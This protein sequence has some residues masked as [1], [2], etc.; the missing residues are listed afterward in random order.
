MSER[1]PIIILGA[2][3][4]GTRLVVDILRT[5]GSLPGRIDNEW[6]EDEVFLDVHRRLVARVTGKRWTE[7]IF[8]MAFVERFRDDASLVP[9]I[10][11]WLALGLG[12][13][14]PDRSVPWHWKCPTAVMF[15]PSWLE[16]YPDALFVHIERDSEDVAR[17]LVRRRQFLRFGR[18]AA[19]Y[20]AMNRR[21][22]EARPAMT[23]YLGLSVET[24]GET[25]PELAGRAGLKP[26]QDALDT[27]RRSIRAQAATGWR[28]DRS[29]LGNLW[30]ATTNARAAVRGRCGKR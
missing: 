13:S 15:L 9:E 29:V 20:E 2:N 3:H 4:A 17:S 25:L 18:A 11:E 5:L 27:A 30:E 7:A 21:V 22:L 14:F 8:D 26:T 12:G 10:R 24:L 28:A 23:H 19:F 16:I 6:L 1:P